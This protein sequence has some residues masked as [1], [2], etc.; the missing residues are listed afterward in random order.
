MKKCTKCLEAKEFSQFSNRG[1]YKH[2][3]KSHCRKCVGIVSK[4][5]EKTRIKT[6]DSLKGSQLKKFWPTLT[7]LEA[8]LEYKKL[9]NQQNGKC[10]ICKKYEVVVDKK[11]GK[12]RELA[13]DHDHS[14]KKVRGLLCNK[15][16][17][18]LGMIKEDFDISL[19]L[20]KYILEHKGI[21]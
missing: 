5:H 6:P 7:N 16:N 2:K 13:V 11:S 9:N 15:C 1:D 20:S 8:L 19:S 21:Q 12:V 14:T 18:A 4:K 3:L 17:V 10:L